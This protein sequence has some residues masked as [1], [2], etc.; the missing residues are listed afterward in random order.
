MDIYICT[1]FCSIDLCVYSSSNSMPSWFLHHYNKIS[2]EALWVLQLSNFSMYIAPC[3]INFKIIFLVPTKE[4]VRVLIRV[5]LNLQTSPAIPSC[6][7]FYVVVASLILV[8]HPWSHAF[9]LCL[10]Y[11][12]NKPLLSTLSPPCL[13]FV[14]SHITYN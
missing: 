3:H 7:I 11:T 6:D 8:F 5:A 1:L 9:L 12:Q 10:Q 2:N 14:F 13:L 4:S